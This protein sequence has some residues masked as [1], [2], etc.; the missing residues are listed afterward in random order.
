M[1]LQWL[2]FRAF[3]CLL[4]IFLFTS[5]Q[6]GRF[7]RGSIEA[8]ANSYDKSAMWVTND[9]YCGAGIGT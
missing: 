9:Y 7:I 2:I 4:Y 8:P 1:H 5:N 3:L 6:L